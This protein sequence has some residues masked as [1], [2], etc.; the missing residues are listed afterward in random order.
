MSD[1]TRRAVG[2]LVVVALGVVAGGC[3]TRVSRAA[4]ASDAM[5]ADG[6]AAAAGNFPVGAVPPV[7]TPNS[8]A[9]GTAAP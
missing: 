1:A 7:H 4:P 3:G 9:T 8:M 5:M 2:A 6:R